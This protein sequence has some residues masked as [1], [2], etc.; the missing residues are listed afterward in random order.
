MLKTTSLMPANLLVIVLALH[1][2]HPKINGLVPD[3]LL[4]S[5][6]TCT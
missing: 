2:Y 5:D 6:I 1:L 4:T 3:Q